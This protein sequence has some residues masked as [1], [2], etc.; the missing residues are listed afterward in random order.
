MNSRKPISNLEIIKN[1]IEEQEIE[2]IDL[3]LWPPATQPAPNSISGGA[4][5]R[6]K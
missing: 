2:S 4:V 5:N 6:V 1:K 3:P